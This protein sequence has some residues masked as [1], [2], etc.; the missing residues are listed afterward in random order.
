MTKF[1]NIVFLLVSIFFMSCEG[2]TEI[3]LYIQ[4]TTESTIQVD[5]TFNGDYYEAGTPF[6]FQIEKGKKRKLHFGE[7][8]GG[9]ATKAETPFSLI[10][11]LIIKDNSGNQIPIDHLSDS[12]IEYN[13]E[14]IT[15]FPSHYRHTY[16]LIVK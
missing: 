4:N 3:E 13:I 10:E 1:L 9:S 16:N 2:V 8:R 5:G 7:G 15:E 12:N 11:T 6:N 14:E